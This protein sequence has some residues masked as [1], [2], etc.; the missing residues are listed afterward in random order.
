MNKTTWIAE[1]GIN[2]HGSMDKAFRMIDKAKA[3]GATFAKFQFYNPAKVLG[4]KHEAF[5]YACQCYFSKDQHETLR[6]YCDKAGIAYLV[7][8]FD[9]RDVEWASNLCSAMKIATR[10]NKRQD[11]IRAVERTKK[12]VYMSVS[13]EL[14]IQKEYSKRFNLMWCI[15]GKYPSS[16]EEVLQYPYRDFGLS[17]HCPDW[18]AS[19]EAYQL[20]CRVFEN[21]LCEASDELGCD[22]SSSLTF[23][24][25]K[26][27]INACTH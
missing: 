13:P 3:S 1:I 21:H 26:K 22:I 15:P 18:T 25:Y 4:T 16:K 8:V 11:F 12:P 2:H 24:D 23:D 7:S 9:I 19:L 20:G 17:S 27:L 14:T 10:M 6:K 5:Q